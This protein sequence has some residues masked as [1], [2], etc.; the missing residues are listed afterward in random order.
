M[1]NVQLHNMLPF[2]TWFGREGIAIRKRAALKDLAEIAARVG[3]R[4]M[5]GLMQ[6]H[7]DLRSEGTVV[8]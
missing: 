2:S 7:S 5:V 1:L 6:S 3:T 8:S 4:W